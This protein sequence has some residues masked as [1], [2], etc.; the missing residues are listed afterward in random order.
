MFDC[1][2][3]NVRIIDGTSAPWYRGSV[4]IKDGRIHKIGTCTAEEENDAAEIVDGED[5]YLAPG[6]IDLHSHSDTSLPKYPLAES[7]ILQGVTTEIGGNCGMSVAPVSA[8]PER[9]KQLKDYVGDLT[10][11]WETVGEIGRAHV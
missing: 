7:R 8:D 1:I 10:Y 9:K 3:K 4:A 2:I 5:L 6:F 11:N